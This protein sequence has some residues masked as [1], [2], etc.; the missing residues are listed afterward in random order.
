M[1]QSGPQGVRLSCR[2]SLATTL[3]G[4]GPGGKDELEELP[5]N[6]VQLRDSL[7]QATDSRNSFRTAV[8]PYPIISRMHSL[9]RLDSLLLTG[10]GGTLMEVNPVTAR[11]FARLGDLLQDSV[12]S[13]LAP[14]QE[15][16][17]EPELARLRIEC[18]GRLGEPARGRQ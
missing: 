11:L 1:S 17:P 14:L 15:P 10:R 3:S 5:T 8:T 12:R 16:M 4:W 2:R 18:A 13:V 6:I 9:N 7:G